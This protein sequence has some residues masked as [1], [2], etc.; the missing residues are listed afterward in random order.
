MNITQLITSAVVAFASTF[1]G[2]FLAFYLHQKSV[3][4]EEKEAFNSMFRVMAYN[5]RQTLDFVKDN[6]PIAR[7]TPLISPSFLLSNVHQNSITLNNVDEERMIRL[8]GS[9]TRTLDIVGQ[10]G[11]KANRFDR[12]PA[13]LPPPP[14]NAPPE[15]KQNFKNAQKEKQN[16]LDEIKNLYNKYEGHLENTCDVFFETVSIY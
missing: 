9:I 6:R 15:H 3:D 12:W 11:V 13:V 1:S 10:Y 4:A 2:V 14:N 7:P 8:V 16:E 5:C